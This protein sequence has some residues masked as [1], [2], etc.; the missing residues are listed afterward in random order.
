MKNKKTG[1]IITLAFVILICTFFYVFLSVNLFDSDFWWHIS[2]GRYIVETGSIPDKDPF[3]YTE[4]L[5][6]N[7]NLMPERENFI[8]KQYWLG[9]IIFYLIYQYAGP[10]GMIILRASI[11]FMVLLLVLWRLTRLKVSFYITFAFIFL[12][13]LDLTRFIGERP[14]LFTILFTPLVFIILEEFRE[15]KSKII[16][17]LLPLMLLWANLHGGFITGAIIIAV[18][19]IFEGT[20]ILL[21]KVSYT[22]SE[23]TIFYAA[24]ILAL[25]ASYINPTGWYA[26]SIALSHK[27]KFLETGIQE[28]QSP[29]Y[30][31]LNKLSSFD[32]GFFPMAFLFPVI[33]LLRNKK[34]D[35]T[36]VIL[37]AGLFTMA[38]KTGRYSIYYVSIAAIVLGK[39]TDI[40]FQ[41]LFIRIP[42]RIFE[43]L[44]SAFAILTLVSAIFFSIGVFKFQWL[45]LDIAKG[46]TVP[47]LSVNFIETNK[48]E[49]NICNS[50]TYGGYVTWR[51]YP[52]KK[53][54]IDTRWLNYTLQQEYAWVMN[55]VQSLSGKKLDED[56]KPLWKRLLDNYN[57]NFILFDTLD[58]H[59]TVPKL[60]L[61]LTEEE[62]WVPI[63][64]EPIAVIFIRNIPKNN[65]IIEK[66][67]L[68][69]EYVYNTVIMIASQ[70]AIYNRY[71]PKYLTTLGKTFYEMKRFDEALVAY[72]YALKRFPTDQ[73][74]KE[75]ITQIESELKQGKK[76][77]KH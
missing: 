27:Y 54:F 22:R 77:E 9:Q 49:G 68:Q 4:N 7:K 58:V 16:F 19:M 24:T 34:M 30:L 70:M 50:S 25:G 41:K 62:E 69:K 71:N 17:L 26:F 8:L 15:K 74:V 63:Y 31:Y 72:R 12:V 29:F 42:E 46:L 57:V 28:Y 13:Y 20:K 21:K 18:Y 56:K 60:L 65:T 45:R 6:E 36:H 23:L 47:E 3:T 43:K 76:N 64:A 1:F 44:I 66:F 14:V 67:K 33:L 2:T 59:G 39:E 38:A 5:Q 37:L 51:L 53:T 48:L 32:Y 55:A 40:L 11:L 73:Y 35:V 52:W 10:K 61:T 75:M